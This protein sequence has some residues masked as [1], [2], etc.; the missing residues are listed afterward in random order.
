ME[1]FS[2]L[3]EFRQAIYDQGLTLAKD[4]QFELIEPCCSA[5]AC[6]PFLS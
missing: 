6:V 4:A 1:Q 5:P 3:I 2:S